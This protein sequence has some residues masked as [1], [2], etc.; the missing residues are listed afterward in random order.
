MEQMHL[1]P[2]RGA[3]AEGILGAGIGCIGDGKGRPRPIVPVFIRR[4]PAERAFAGFFQR[5]VIY[6]DPQSWGD[7]AGW[8]QFFQPSQGMPRQIGQPAI[9][10]RIPDHRDL[11]PADRG[12]DGGA[13]RQV[14]S[15]HLRAAG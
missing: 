11:R 8:P 6:G 4:E 2:P 5:L 14:R 15:A 7:Y 12:I 9:T 13:M 1:L 3:A 10:G